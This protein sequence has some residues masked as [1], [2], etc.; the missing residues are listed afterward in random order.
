MNYTYFILD[1]LKSEEEF[2]KLEMTLTGTCEGVYQR[3]FQDLVESLPWYNGADGERHEIRK[4]GVRAVLLRMICHGDETV[5]IDRWIDRA[6]IWGKLHYMRTEA[7]LLDLQVQ[8]GT[9]PGNAAVFLLV[10]PVSPKGRIS[11]Y[12]YLDGPYALKA[13]IRD[14]VRYVGDQQPFQLAPKEMLFTAKPGLTDPVLDF[15]DHIPETNEGETEKDYCR[16]AKQINAA[17]AQEN[18]Y[19]KQELKEAAK[20]KTALEGHEGLLSD[21]QEYTEFVKYLNSID[22]VL[23]MLNTAQTLQYGIRSLQASGDRDGLAYIQHVLRL[24]K[25]YQKDHQIPDI[26][27]GFGK[28]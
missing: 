21:L 25:Q 14:Y 23:D 10:V 26:S 27:E 16:R 28:K 11:L 4:N 9:S 2:N 17:M 15:P 24:G 19:M 1:K 3:R 12:Y 22:H 18:Y 7:C 8:L 20:Y 6:T 5:D 13:Q